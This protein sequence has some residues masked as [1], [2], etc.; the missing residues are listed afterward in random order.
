MRKVRYRVWVTRFVTRVD[1]KCF[2]LPLKDPL[3]QFLNG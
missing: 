2:D 1:R 3:K